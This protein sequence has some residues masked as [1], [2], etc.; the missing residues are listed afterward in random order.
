MAD[1]RLYHDAALARFYDLDNGWTGD[2][3]YCLN[4]ARGS[5]T[6][7]DLGC[8]TGNLAIRIAGDHG[9]DVTGV[10]P[11]G[12]MLALARAKRG[13][14]AVRWVQADARELDL[15]RSFDLIVMTGHAFQVFLT[16]ADR[17]A[18]LATIARHLAPG[19]RF[20]LDSRNPAM[21]EW[22]DWAPDPSR[23]W[24]DD[25]LSGRVEAWN[26]AHFDPTRDV[27]TYETHYRLADGRHLDA[28]SRIAFPDHAS[29]VRQIA[30]AGL[31]VDRWM[32]DWQGGPLHDA[33]PEFIPLGALA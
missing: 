32:G 26:T 18:C 14:G 10:D 8:G 1:D 6:V 22:L 3:S 20:I 4:L 5:G 17:A 28:L 15:G 24:F 29:L 7:L 9:A 33:C 2:R 16:G 23:R 25:P 30:E 19:G 12:P 31:R 27:V 13:A 21:R 11:A